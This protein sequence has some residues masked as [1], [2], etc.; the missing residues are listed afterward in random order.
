MSAAVSSFADKL[1]N[2]AVLAESVSAAKGVTASA[3]AEMRAV[4][5]QNAATGKENSVFP[6]LQSIA[7]ASMNSEEY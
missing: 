7:Q 4:N 2:I 1:N 3:L 6:S 5:E